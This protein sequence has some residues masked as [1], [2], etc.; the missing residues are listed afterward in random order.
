MPILSWRTGSQNSDDPQVAQ[1]P[2]RTFSDDAYHLTFSL[3]WTVS[4]DRGTSVDAK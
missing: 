3:P 1:N 4:A 2:R